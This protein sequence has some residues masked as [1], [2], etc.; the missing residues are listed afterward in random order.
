MLER[1]ANQRYLLG[2]Q[3]DQI[4]G[5]ETPLDFGIAAERPGAGAG[6]VD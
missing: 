5:L 4:G 6:R 2:V 3:I 1:L